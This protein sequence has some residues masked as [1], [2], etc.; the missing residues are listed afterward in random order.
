MVPFNNISTTKTT[1]FCLFL[2]QVEFTDVSEKGENVTEPDNHS[3]RYKVHFVSQTI[4]PQ[5]PKRKKEHG[6]ALP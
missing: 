1:D 4:E 3:S 5:S 2:L 6:N